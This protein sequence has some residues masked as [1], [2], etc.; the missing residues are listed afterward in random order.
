[1]FSDAKCSP[2]ARAAYLMYIIAWNFATKWPKKLRLNWCISLVVNLKDRWAKNFETRPSKTAIQWRHHLASACWLQVAHLLVRIVFTEFAIVNAFFLYFSFCTMN[3]NLKLAL[4]DI[5]IRGLSAFLAAIKYS[6]SKT[7]ILRRLDNPIPGRRGRPQ[8][9]TRDQE[10][11]FRQV[12]KSLEDHGRAI[13]IN[14]FLKMVREYAAK[15]GWFEAVML[16]FFAWRSFLPQGLKA[17]LTP[18]GLGKI[19]EDQNDCH[20]SNTEHIQNHNF[21]VSLSGCVRVRPDS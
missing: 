2:C 18:I 10:D 12:G 8:V 7:T 14:D 19:K 3:P 5:R 1:M 17:V 15:K 20:T 21:T 9:F 13:E 11:L 6:V 16:T 4:E